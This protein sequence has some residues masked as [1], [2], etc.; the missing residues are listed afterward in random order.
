[1]GRRISAF[2]NSVPQRLNSGDALTCRRRLFSA[3]RCMAA[4]GGILGEFVCYPWL[5]ETRHTPH[6]SRTG[7]PV[8]HFCAAKQG[9]GR[10]VRQP[11]SSERC[12]RQ[13]EICPIYFCLCP[14][15][16]YLRP[17]SSRFSFDALPTLSETAHGKV[18]GIR[19]KAGEK[20][21]R[22][23]AL[24]STSRRPHLLVLSRPYGH[25]ISSAP[26]PRAAMRL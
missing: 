20:C 14:I 6:F 5:A 22:E 16:F 15:Y 25:A 21:R 18:N 8:P 4:F 13:V 12:R 11:M 24:L 7:E 19:H 1:M 26:M 17:A 10:A 9:A 2:N 23:V 3:C